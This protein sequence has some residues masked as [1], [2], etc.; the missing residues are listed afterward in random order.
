MVTPVLEGVLSR[1]TQEYERRLLRKENEL[2]WM[3]DAVAVAQRAEHA[4]LEALEDAAEA[5]EAASVAAAAQA[6]AAQAAQADADAAQ[7]Q[8]VA[9]AAAAVVTPPPRRRDASPASGGGSGGKEGSGGGAA[10]GGGGGGGG[11]APSSRSRSLRR[12]GSGT[13]LSSAAA[14][15][16]RR[17]LAQLRDALR[18]LRADAAAALHDAAHDAERLGALLPPLAARAARATLL[19][20]ENRALHSQLLDLKGAIR[21]VCR[22]RPLLPGEGPRAAVAALGPRDEGAPP[23]DVQVEEPA[24]ITPGGGTAA[25]SASSAS[26][27]AAAS[28]ASAAAVEPVL[29][30]FAYDRVFGPEAAQA[31]VFAEV[32]PLVR[33]VCDG[34]DACIFAYGQTGSGKT[35]TMAG[36]G[37]ASPGARAQDARGVNY[38]ALECLF[39]LAA[40]RAADVSYEFSVQMVEIY[41]ENVRDLLAPQVVCADG[42]LEAPRVEVRLAAS[43]GGGGTGG[44]GGSGVPDAASVRV[45]CA[46]D[47]GAAVARG[48]AARAVGATALNDRSSRSHAILIVTV[49]GTHV[50]PPLGDAASA[51][52]TAAMM[53]PAVGIT[54]R[55]TLHLIDLAGSE[56]VK[57][58]EAAGERLREAQHINRSLSALGDVMAA[59]QS[60]NRGHVPYRNS[61][62]TSLLAAPLAGAGKALMLVHVSPASG[63]VAE[64]LSTLHFATRVAAV[65]L[66]AARRNTDGG[67]AAAA[68]AAARDVAAA[69]DEAARERR[70]AASAAAR[71]EELERALA[72]ALARNSGGGG[73]GSGR[74]SGSAHDAARSPADAVSFASPLYASP[75]APALQP[76]PQSAPFPFSPPKPPR[77]PSSHGSFAAGGAASSSPSTPLF[78]TSRAESAAAAAAARVRAVRASSLSHTALTGRTAAPVLAPPL[79]AE[80]SSPA[81]LSPAALSTLRASTPSRG[82]S[83]GALRAPPA[84]RGWV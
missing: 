25:T 73:S 60:A 24:R 45:A 48:E 81:A 37:T 65:E 13:E 30:A 69:R 31:E 17:E 10:G 82:A 57:S 67:A 53:P 79:R 40:A 7:A 47:V 39:E 76:R 35:H 20:A 50:A 71:C 38:R 1:I 9:D 52:A 63:A 75:S 27:S 70:A 18:A 43:L 2:L 23:C 22:V 41:N 14:V 33:A 11:I 28:S 84:R 16:A 66:G 58:S 72:A 29:R 77:P 64:T 34:Y 32:A 12:G 42:S 5:G 4:A 21:V 51:S 54:T 80:K 78:A 62:L 19:A 8:V 15:A 3:R 44:G 6:K 56:R 68:A 55:A 26:P 74:G 59:L 46:A 83:S 49:A 61:K 36:P